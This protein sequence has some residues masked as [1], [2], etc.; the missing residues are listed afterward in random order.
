MTRPERNPLLPDR[1][2]KGDFFLCDILDAAPKGDLP[3]MEHPLFSVS[4]RPDTNVRRYEQGEHFVEVTPSVKGLA[5]VFDRDILI[6]CISQLVRALD[7][8]TKVSRTVRFR[9]VDLMRSTNR[10]V[11]GK[12]YQA[13]V[14]AFERLAGTRITTNVIE[15]ETYVTD[16]FGLI[17][18]WRI[19]RERKDGR[20][21]EIEVELSD[22]VFEAINNYEVLTLDRDYFRLRKP[23]ERR[24]YEIARKHCGA[25]KSWKIGLPKLKYKI[26]SNSSDKEF[27][28]LVSRIINEPHDHIPQY[29]FEMREGIVHVTNRNFA[30]TPKT[31]DTYAGRLEPDAYDGARQRAPGWDVYM[32]EQKWRA[33]MHKNGYSSAHPTKSFL[34]FCAEHYE[35]NGAP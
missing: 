6:F 8:G 7:E 31:A 17:D 19:V 30:P 16:G 23:I 4:T 10:D 22:W 11:S 26:G 18:R 3:S 25:Q 28:R 14:A 21:Q 34:S 13:L 12:G 29:S 2:P 27:K 35:R 33:W 5:T 32:L 24:L 9:A 15:N 20:M 1:M